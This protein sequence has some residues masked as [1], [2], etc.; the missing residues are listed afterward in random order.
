MNA[1]IRRIAFVA[2]ALVGA[3]VVGTTYWQAWAAGDL[4]ARQDNAIKRVA[5]F[6]I[7]R[8]LIYAAD[9]TVLAANRRIRTNGQTF[10]LRRYPHGSL[11]SNVVGYSTQG[12]SRA[13]LE[14]A[15]NDYL[16]GSNSN[17]HTV[18]ETTLNGLTGQTIK[19]NSLVLTIDPAVQRSAIRALGSNCGAAVALEPATGRVLAMATSPRYDASKVEGDFGSIVGTHA[20]CRPSAPLF[21]RATAGLYVPGSTFKLVT[22]AAALD[23][24]AVTPRTVFDD[25][26]YCTEY[27][28]PVYN[29][30]DQSG[31]EQFG[32]VTFA[33]ALQHSINAVFCDVGKQL[34]ALKILEYGKRFG[35]YSQPGLET[36]GSEQRP[37]GLYRRGSLFIPKHDY[38]VDPGRLAFG[39]ERLG[40]T[41]LQMAMVAATIAN[42]GVLMQPYLV[43]KILRPNGKV[44]RRTKPNEV[45][46]V[47]KP[48]TAAELTA[49]MVSVVNGGT[50]TA[51]QIPGV[52]VAGKT[53]TAETG[54]AH[55]NTTWF[56]SFAPALRSQVAVA[57]VLERQTGTGGTTAAPIAK[58]IMTTALGR[59]ASP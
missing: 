57:V 48:T 15:M 18:L 19:G 38:Q 4:A 27:G 44:L 51:A 30:A 50:G 42:G 33:E 3:L 25:R 59:Q 29:F 41:P 10:Y 54:I 47:M 23:T 1:E 7:K 56:V 5:E 55:L 36:P 46:R 17:L 32:S 16:T 14:R 24:G 45:G 53:G 11:L 52:Q 39:Q 31:P 34:G 40:V 12:R 58:E 2:L 6:K 22:A 35:M 37:S 21:N 9:G 43:E 26:G 28:K 49:M 13:G 20:A 8:G